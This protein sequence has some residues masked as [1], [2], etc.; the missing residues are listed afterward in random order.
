MSLMVQYHQVSRGEGDILNRTVASA[1]V[2]GSRLFGGDSVCNDA[3]SGT[4]GTIF[5]KRG[6]ARRIY[7]LT[8][9]RG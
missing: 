1:S 3:K 6:E 9:T 7:D 5:Y 2:T 4:G 8:E